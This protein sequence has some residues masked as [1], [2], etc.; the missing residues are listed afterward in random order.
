LETALKDTDCSGFIK[1]LLARVTTEANPL[2]KGGDLLEILKI[3]TGPGQLGLQRGGNDPRSGAQ[4]LGSVGSG[5]A[6]IAFGTAS[7]GYADRGGEALRQILL[8]FD[9]LSA[10]HE[11]I[12]LAGAYKYDDL[13]LATAA[14]QMPNAAALGEPPANSDLLGKALFYSNYWDTE[15]RKYCKKPRAPYVP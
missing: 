12:H 14:S 3:I 1:N 6:G 10:L 4:A 5:K 9:S 11:L 2:V 15:L 7:G 13:T 8:Y